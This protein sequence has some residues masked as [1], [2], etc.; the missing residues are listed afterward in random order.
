M[1]EQMKTLR[2]ESTDAGR[3]MWQKVD[4]AASQLPEWVRL[5]VE[6]KLASFAQSESLKPEPQLD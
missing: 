6:E 2:N 3:E 4:R 5:R 1:A